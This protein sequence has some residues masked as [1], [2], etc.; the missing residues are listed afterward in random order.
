MSLFLHFQHFYSNIKH[1]HTKFR[2][3]FISK[4]DQQT[5]N[6]ERKTQIAFYLFETGQFALNK[7]FKETRLSG[8]PFCLLT[9]GRSP[10]ECSVYVPLSW[11]RRR[12][13]GCRVF[14][15]CGRVYIYSNISK[16]RPR[17]NTAA[18]LIITLDTGCDFYKV[19]LR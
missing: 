13:R 9:I 4:V 6:K 5:N 7:V 8:W 17:K 1:Y 11:R 18:A 14:I 3:N 15:L 16:N 19:L 10:W 2:P 12:Y